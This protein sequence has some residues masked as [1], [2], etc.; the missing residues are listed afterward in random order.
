MEILAG[1]GGDAR[2]QILGVFVHHCATLILNALGVRWGE[3]K[4][5]KDLGSRWCEGRAKLSCQ[6]DLDV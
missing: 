6:T 5:L 1:Y 2:S 3:K 4:T